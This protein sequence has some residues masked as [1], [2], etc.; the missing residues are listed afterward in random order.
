MVIILLLKWVLNNNIQSLVNIFH[1]YLRYNYSIRINDSCEPIYI[2]RHDKRNTYL[3]LIKINSDVT[4]EI[5][6]RE[7]IEL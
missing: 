5:Y 7:M 2:N 6:E 4:W 3:V 1:T